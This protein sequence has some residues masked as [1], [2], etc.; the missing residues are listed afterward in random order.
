[1]HNAHFVI[2]TIRQP[3]HC[4]ALYALL[5][6]TWLV[7]IT[8]YELFQWS[9]CSYIGFLTMNH[10]PQNCAARSAVLT[11]M[12]KNALRHLEDS[13][14]SKS[15]KWLQVQIASSRTNQQR[16]VLADE[17]DGGAAEQAADGDRAYS[18]VHGQ[19]RHMRR[20]GC[21]ACA[22][23][24]CKHDCEYKLGKNQT[25]RRH[26]GSRVSAS[27]KQNNQKC[28]P[29]RTQNAAQIGLYK[30]SVIAVEAETHS[31]AVQCLS[32]AEYLLL[33]GQ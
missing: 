8:N 23:T 26:L 12:D 33:L 16:A 27:E 10:A 9:H 19:P 3:A 24:G 17:E 29:I 15:S 30:S 22:T 21:H 1:M 31:S 25:R 2:D 13:P 11:S 4:L 18:V 5:Q 32:Q 28:D 20:P 14:D 7:C 6:V